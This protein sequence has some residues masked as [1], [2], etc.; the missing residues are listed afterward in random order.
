MTSNLT[1][2]IALC[3]AL[4]ASA[5]LGGIIPTE[6]LAR[7]HAPWRR[8]AA[9]DAAVPY[10]YAYPYGPYGYNPYYAPVL[11]G[12]WAERYA[13]YPYFDAFYQ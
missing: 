2:K 5:A 9:L 6:A 11:P 1:R 7:C 8:F 4:C 10:G 13:P 3:G 12:L